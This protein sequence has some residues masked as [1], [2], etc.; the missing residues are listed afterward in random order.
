MVGDLLAF[1]GAATWGSYSVAIVPLLRRYSV[2]R[3]SAVL[4]VG[5]FALIT[6]MPQLLDQ[7]WDLARLVWAG[8]AFAV[9]GPLVLTNFLWFT[10]IERVGPS[11]A[12]LVTNLQPFLAALFA[13]V[14]LSEELTWLQ[15]AGGMTIGP[16][17]SSP[18]VDRHWS[19]RDRG[20]RRRSCRP[21]GSLAEADPD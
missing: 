20:A 3:I 8:F 14:L 17:S 7:G 19:R 6:G 4:V 21:P 15:V 1:L 12:T 16:R 13:V 10:A 2:W 11:R 18:G 5:Q 9:L